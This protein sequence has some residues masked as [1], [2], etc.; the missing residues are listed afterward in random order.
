MQK[1]HLDIFWVFQPRYWS[2][3]FLADC[4]IFE[5]P[6]RWRWT[7]LMASNALHNERVSS[8]ST[9][10]KKGGK[11]QNQKTKVPHDLLILIWGIIYLIPYNPNFRNK[12]DV[13]LLW[14]LSPNYVTHSSDVCLCACTCALGLHLAL[15]YA[16]HQSPSIIEGMVCGK[17]EWNVVF[18]TLRW[19]CV[20]VQGCLWVQFLTEETETE[21]TE[22]PERMCKYVFLLS[23]ML[24]GNYVLWGRDRSTGE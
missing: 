24:D 5:G 3:L 13:A 9:G 7:R 16:L 10:L 11:K 6:K 4:V 1:H 22:R 23:I 12:S 18:L 8:G 14:S 20:H 15:A 2:D 19:E 21:K 17:R